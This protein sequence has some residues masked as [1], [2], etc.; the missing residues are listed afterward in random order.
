MKRFVTV[1][2]VASA[3]VLLVGMGQAWAQGCAMCQASLPGAED[4]LSHGFNYSIYMFLGVTY[5]LIL[6]GGGF[7]GYTYWRASTPRPETRVLAFQSLTKE[8]Q[9]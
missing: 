6:A 3:A 8:E 2:M 4:P 9:P 7:I 5:G 1:M